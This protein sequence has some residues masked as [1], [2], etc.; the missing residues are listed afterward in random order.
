M[1]RKATEKDADAIIKLLLQVHRVHSTIRPD[2]FKEG[3]TKYTKDELIKV[4]SDESRPIFVY[5]EDGI[6][7]YAFCILEDFTKEHSLVPYKSLYIDDLCTDEK[8]RGKGIAHKL[9]EKVAEYAKSI[10]C[11]NLTLNVW[12]GNDKAKQFYQNLG[13][14]TQKTVMETILK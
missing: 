12:E 11:Y 2:L 13:M 3:E 7:G 9:Y 5:D 8:Q 14:K 10:G 1:I 4:I 6:K